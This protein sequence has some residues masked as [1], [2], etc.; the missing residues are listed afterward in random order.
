MAL[1]LVED[2]QIETDGIFKY[3]LIEITQRE[4][5][6]KEP[7]EKRSKTIVRI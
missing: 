6:G 3:I 7:R 1:D 4:R 2:V 5:K